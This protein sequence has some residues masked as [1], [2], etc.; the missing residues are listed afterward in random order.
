MSLV[1]R[2]SSVSKRYEGVMR[3]DGRTFRRGRRVLGIVAVLPC[4]VVTNGL[5][6]HLAPYHVPSADRSRRTGDGHEAIHVIR[7]HLTPKP[8]LHAS[9][10]C[11]KHQPQMLYA[12]L[13]KK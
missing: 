5:D 8:G 4:R 7:E 1:Q 13:L 3:G 9:H 2:L 6:D 10:R 11:P 12:Y